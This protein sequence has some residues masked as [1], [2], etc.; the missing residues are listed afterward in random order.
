MTHPYLKRAR[1][2]GNPLI[3]GKQ[4]TFIWKGES[5]PLLIGD[6]NGWEGGSPDRPGA[7]YTGLWAYSTEFP[8]DAYI[9]YVFWDGSERLGDLS[10][11]TKPERILGNTNHFSICAGESDG[12]VGSPGGRATR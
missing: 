6:F 5:A 12:P 4:A 9:E 8:A 2:E 1:I 3:D 10:T 7:G 11:A